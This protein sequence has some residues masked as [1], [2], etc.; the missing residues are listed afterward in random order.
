MTIRWMIGLAMLLSL[1]G[2]QT[3][4]TSGSAYMLTGR[5]VDLLAEPTF[6]VGSGTEKVFYN[7][8]AVHVNPDGHGIFDVPIVATEQLLFSPV[9]PFSFVM[10]VTGS[11]PYLYAPFP[12][13]WMQNPVGSAYWLTREVGAWSIALPEMLMYSGSFVT[14][15]AFDTVFHDVPVIVFGFP[16]RAW[17]ALQ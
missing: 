14:T 10:R 16:I 3:A 2:C 7:F 15:M 13:A 5:Y 8:Q 17:K 11:E 12:T 9:W 4:T 6:D 1:A